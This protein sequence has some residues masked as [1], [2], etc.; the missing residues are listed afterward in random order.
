[1]IDSE[2]LDISSEAPG[3]LGAEYVAK[4]LLALL[5]L[6]IQCNRYPTRSQG[7]TSFAWPSQPM[8]KNDGS[9]D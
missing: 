9:L 6:P 7:R 5:E 1:M 2:I 3:E 4:A 8:M